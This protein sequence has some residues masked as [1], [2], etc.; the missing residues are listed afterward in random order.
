MAHFFILK[1]A[2]ITMRATA[3][4]NITYLEW[5]PSSCG[6]RNDMV[7]QPNEKLSCKRK[8]SFSQFELSYVHSTGQVQSVFALAMFP[9]E[10]TLLTQ[11]PE[12]EV[13][14]SFG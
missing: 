8:G 11:S 6:L 3:G 4:I 13:I 5:R 9:V 10:L 7:V 1:V 14:S 2:A 12:M